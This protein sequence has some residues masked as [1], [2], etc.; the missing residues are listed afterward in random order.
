MTNL[1]EIKN[2]EKSYLKVGVNFSGDRV[3]IL[4]GVNLTIEEGSCVGLIGESGSG[5]STLARLIMGL[6][7]PDKG[8]GSILIEGQPVKQWLKKNKGKMSVVFQDYTASVNSRYTVFE[9]IAEPIQAT[10]E[11]TDLNQQI[12][13]L[14]TRVGLEKEISGRYPH[15]LSGGQL[16]RVCIARAIAT[17]PR[18][19]VLDEAISSLDVSVQS[20]V[21]K[22]LHQLRE[23]M[24]MTYLFVAHDLQAVSHLCNK[25]F[26][27]YQGKVVEEL[28]SGELSL[29]KNPYARELLASV[30]PFEV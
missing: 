15:E 24:Q 13:M 19:I 5:K 28:K 17:N 14:L 9:A 25:I 21:L 6:E 26:I 20:Q 8:R 11:T 23:E 10:G 4:N 18:F 29:A 16:Q 27:L 22:L 12:A 2:L 1:V 30:I 3:K 7:K